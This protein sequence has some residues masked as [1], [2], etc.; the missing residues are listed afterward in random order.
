MKL[1]IKNALAGLC[2]CA[3]IL[4]ISSSPAR[5]QVL[6]HSG[7]VAG[8]AGLYYTGTTE[9]NSLCGDSSDCPIGNNHGVYGANGGYSPSPWVTII[10]EYGFVPVYS[11]EGVTIHN[12]FYGGGARFNLN[13]KSKVVGYAIFTAGGDKAS[14]SV[15]GE[16]SQSNSG[17]SLSF[18]GGA[19]CYI[20]HNWGVRPEFRYVRSEY[21]A[22]GTT[23]GFNNFGMFWRSLLPVW[24]YEDG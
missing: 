23:L 16:G 7:D 10:G 5:A 11:G 20:G 18:G 15:T 21:S 22:G 3:T 6:G 14:E 2:V 19:S 8:Y 9:A 17:Y 4:L 24:W 12:Q 1:F 13:P